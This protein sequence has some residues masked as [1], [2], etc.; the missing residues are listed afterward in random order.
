MLEELGGIESEVRQVVT[1]HVAKAGY[2]NQADADLVVRV[3]LEKGKSQT[4]NVRDWFR[5]PFGKANET[6]TFTPSR[7]KYEVTYRDNVLTSVTSR[8]FTVPRTLRLGQNESA[9]QAA[10]R[11]CRP[12]IDFFKR[13]WLPRKGPL[14]PDSKESLG[15]STL[16]RDGWQTR[17]GE[18]CKAGGRRGGP[19]NR[20]EKNP[21]K[22]LPRKGLLTS[23]NR[24]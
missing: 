24:S 1:E 17:I 12:D 4:V 16:T 19:G 15:G 18:D 5:G 20:P 22:K 23:V 11:Y 7:G 21:Q 10:D 6:I 2:T 3:W 13:L 14:L 8:E 9:Q